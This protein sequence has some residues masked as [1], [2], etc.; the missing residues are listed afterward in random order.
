MAWCCGA[1]K[2]GSFATI[3][4]KEILLHNVPILYCPVCQSIEPHPKI[5]DNLEF[6]TDIAKDDGLNE[7]DIDYYLNL[8][9]YGN[10]FENCSTVNNGNKYQ[11]IQSQIDISLDLLTTAK[12]INDKDWQNTL[13]K[14]LKKLSKMLKDE[15]INH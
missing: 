2:I 13:K 15:I 6:V 8:K 5:K 9:E 10:L 1:S 11:V 7:L 14:R 4:K 12:G 3:K